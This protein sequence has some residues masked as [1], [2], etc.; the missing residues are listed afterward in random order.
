M[1]DEEPSEWDKLFDSLIGKS[2]EE[3][4]EIILKWS[5]KQY[6]TRLPIILLALNGIVYVT[7]RRYSKYMLFGSIGFYIWMDRVG[8]IYFFNYYKNKFFETQ[9]L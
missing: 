8:R 3:K 9:L 1:G 7:K 2:A 6:E 5:T 4:D